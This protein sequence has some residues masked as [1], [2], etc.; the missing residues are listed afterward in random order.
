[1]MGIAWSLRKQLNL[2]SKRRIRRL[3]ATGGKFF[4]ISRGEL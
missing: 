1:M 4:R 3:R 2:P